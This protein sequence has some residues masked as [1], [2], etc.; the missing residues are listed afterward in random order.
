MQVNILHTS[1]QRAINSNMDI[2]RIFVKYIDFQIWVTTDSDSS[3]EDKNDKTKNNKTRI[4]QN[5]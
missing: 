5:T 4:Q 2:D 1:Q 3:M